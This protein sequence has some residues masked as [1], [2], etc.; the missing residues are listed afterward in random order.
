M[1]VEN[2]VNTAMIPCVSVVMSVY[3]DIQDLPVTLGSI[4]DQSLKSIEIILVDDGNSLEDKKVIWSLASEDYRIKV[5]ENKANIGLTRSLIRGCNAA[6]GDFIARIDNG[7]LMVP[8]KRL[9]KQY[10]I[11][12]NDD[13]LGIVGGEIEVVD[14]LNRNRYRSCRGLKLHESLVS[15]GEIR[16][17]FSHVTVMF[18]KSVYKAAGGYNEKNSVGQETWLW[19]RMLHYGRGISLPDIF[20]IAPMKIS[21]ISVA[22]NNK[23]IVGKIKRIIRQN[24]NELQPLNMVKAL[25][26]ISVEVIKLLIPIRYRVHL[27]YSK[28]Y[29]YLGKIEKKHLASLETLAQ[30]Y[31]DCVLSVTTGGIDGSERQ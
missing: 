2:T 28:N 11:L 23:Q 8:K 7:D 19:P 9:E 31:K 21:S 1:Q 20:A 29:K 24:K 12:R 30:Y 16:S 5:V 26:A 17:I 6:K 18:R 13:S 4:R 3:R 27:N 14:F 15:L 10:D 22:H 25:C